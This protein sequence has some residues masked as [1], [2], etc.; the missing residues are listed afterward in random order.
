MKAN[1]EVVET[2]YWELIHGWNDKSAPQ[3]CAG[4]AND[5]EMIGFD[6]SH[7][8]GQSHI[9]QHINEIFTHHTPAPYYCKV[10]AVRCLGEDVAMLRAIA[11]MVS[12]DQLLINPAVNTHQTLIAVKSAD[13]WQISLFQNTPAQFHG[14]PEQ[15]KAMTAELQ[16]LVDVEKELTE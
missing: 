15:V 7:F 13:Q 8:V 11:G 5:G 16:A 9:Q 4:F 14:Q 10:T 3:M 12:S 6:G 1:T 2:L